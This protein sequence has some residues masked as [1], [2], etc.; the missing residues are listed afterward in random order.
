[1]EELAFRGIL[2]GIAT[3]CIALFVG[4]SAWECGRR[5]AGSGMATTWGPVQGCQVEIRPGVFFPED[6]VRAFNE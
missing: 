2:V 4:L 6:R 5:W 3:V 1:M